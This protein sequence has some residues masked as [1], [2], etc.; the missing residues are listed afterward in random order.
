MK[1]KKYAK[2]WREVLLLVLLFTFFFG[3]GYMLPVLYL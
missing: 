1:L 3:A 2:H